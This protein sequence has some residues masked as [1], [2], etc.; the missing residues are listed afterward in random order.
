MTV[1]NIMRKFGKDDTFFKRIF[2]ILHSTGYLHCIRKYQLDFLL[3]P[4]LF[5]FAIIKLSVFCEENK[6]NCAESATQG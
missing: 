3:Q 5:D 2:C 4:L 1:F 6:M